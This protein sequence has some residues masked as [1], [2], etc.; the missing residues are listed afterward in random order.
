MDEEYQ[1][2]NRAL[3]RVY[4][5]ILWT[6]EHEL[7][8]STFSDLTIKEMH[9]ID[10]ISLHGEYPAAQV[11]KKLHLSPGTMTATAD[12]LVRKG[13]VERRRD[14]HDRR[15]IRLVLT[16]RGRVFYRAHRAFHNLLVEKFLDGADDAQ[17]RV[18][19]RSLANLEKFLDQ[20]S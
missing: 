2:I 14:P 10:A 20:Y 4:N 7:R 11:A 6:E 17:M 3:I 8:K 19:R 16:K 5:Q 18:I 13:Y 1:G 15:V 9:A 12:R